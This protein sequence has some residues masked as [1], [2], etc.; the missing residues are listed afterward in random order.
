[1][2]K[3]L[4]LKSGRTTR[5]VFSADVKTSRTVFEAM[6]SMHIQDCVKRGLPV[7]SFEYQTHKDES[8]K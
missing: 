8:D 7:P 2:T 4:Y 3:T 1:M 5:P 6:E